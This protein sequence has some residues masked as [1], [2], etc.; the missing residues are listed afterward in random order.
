MSE[1]YFNKLIK[2]FSMYFSSNV[3]VAIAGIFSYPVWTR[4]FSQAEYGQMSLAST[5]LALFITFSKFGIQHA[6]LRFYSEFKERKRE[7]DIT[8]YYTTAFIS[9]LFFSF[10]I[11]AGFILVVEFVISSQWDVEY[12]QILRILALLIIFDAINSIFFIFLRAEQNVKRYTI[13]STFHRYLTIAFSLLF[14]LVFKLGLVGFFIGW[15]LADGLFAIYLAFTFFH[16]GKIRLTSV[17]MSLLKE[18]LS[19]GLPLIGFELSSVLLATGDRYVIQFLLGSAAVGLYSSAYNL[20]SYLADFFANPFQL[21][22]KPIFISIWEK[23]GREQTQQFLSKVFKIYCMVAIPIVFAV[24][25]FGRDF[26]GLLASKEFEDGYVIMPYIILGYTI[27][28]ANVIYAAGLY[29]KKKTIA[30]L[31]IQ[32]SSAVLNIALNFLLIPNFGLLGA[33][34]A[35]LVAYSFQVI[36]K[37]KIAFKIV[38]FRLPL[39]DIMKYII[40]SLIMVFVMLSIKNLGSALLFI[41]VIAGFL[42][43]CAGIFLLENQIRMNTRIL[44]Q[45][46]F[47]R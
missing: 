26:L 41:R 30:M 14:V 33:A 10:I 21:M 39:Y 32:F 9:V 18:S 8:F 42:T 29:L 37:V 3:L 34:I 46:I 6:A 31:L 5:T 47:V 40:L 19:Y 35:T 12:L 15:A 45:K 23:D 43:Y 1:T 7:L 4:V 11:A 2:Q 24:T 16:Q 22:I 20:T 28:K 44:I 38:S 36:F 27:Y 17:S 13:I 25:I